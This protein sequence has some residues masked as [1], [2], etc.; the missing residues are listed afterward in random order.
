LSKINF[1]ETHVYADPF[2]DECFKIWRLVMKE[3][4]LTRL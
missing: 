3:E 2:R 4:M 1:T